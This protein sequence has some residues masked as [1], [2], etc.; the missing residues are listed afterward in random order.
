M[1]SSELARNASNAAQR[2]QSL[3]RPGVTGSSPLGRTLEE[4]YVVA[5]MVEHSAMIR[6][7]VNV[8]D[9]MGGGWVAQPLP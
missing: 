2:E 6:R 1:G 4:A 3:H 5:C 9:K 7:L 8:D